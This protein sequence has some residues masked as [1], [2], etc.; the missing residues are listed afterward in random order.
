MTIE[1]PSVPGTGFLWIVTS[2]AEK[3]LVQTEPKVDYRQRCDHRTKGPLGAV[4]KQ[5][6][7]FRAT[8]RGFTELVVHYLRPWEKDRA[9]QKSVRLRIVVR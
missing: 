7:R 4:E 5:I 1:L 8:E 3:V 9:P 6:L 2:N